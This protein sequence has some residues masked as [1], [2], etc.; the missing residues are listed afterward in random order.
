MPI[1]I[2]I[3]NVAVIAVMGLLSHFIHLMGWQFALGGIIGM[4]VYAFT[5]RMYHGRWF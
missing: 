2:I 3:G 1:Q 5:L 4:F